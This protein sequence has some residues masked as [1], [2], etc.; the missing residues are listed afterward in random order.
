MNFCCRPS[1]LPEGLNGVPRLCSAAVC[2][3]AEPTIASAQESAGKAHIRCRLMS[4]STT[5]WIGARH[6]QRCEYG[7]KA[8]KSRSQPGR[9]EIWHAHF[10]HTCPADVRIARTRGEDSVGIVHARERVEEVRASLAQRRNCTSHAPR[11]AVD[12]PTS[13]LSVPHAVVGRST[14]GALSS[15]SAP[16][17]QAPVLKAPQPQQIARTGPEELIHLL[18]GTTLNGQQQRL[19]AAA[20]V[21]A[22]VTSVSDLGCVLGMSRGI[23]AAFSENLRADSTGCRAT[24]GDAIAGQA[25]LALADEMRRD[26]GLDTA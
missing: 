5:T 17:T 18:A 25:M 23:L 13:T 11:T 8:R 2:E 10:T 20:L 24:P 21:G 7:V 6:G 4:N 19:L 1:G 22:G 15:A 26:T 3:K 12:S 14:A 9:I 16:E